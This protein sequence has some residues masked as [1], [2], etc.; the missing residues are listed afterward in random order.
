MAD[1]EPGAQSANAVD[2]TEKVPSGWWSWGLVKFRGRPPMGKGGLGPKSDLG[3]K[4]QGACLE[5]AGDPEA[6]SMS[7]FLLPWEVCL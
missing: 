1:G 5:E 3:E 4:T 7:W 2:L 6:A